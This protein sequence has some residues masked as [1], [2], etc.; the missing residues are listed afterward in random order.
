MD[1]L[2]ALEMAIGQIEKQHGKGAI[3]KLGEASAKFEVPVIP[4]GSLA[5]DMALGI[6]GVPRGRVSE[7]YG[8]E[9]SGKTTL[10]LQV[11]AEA[12]KLGGIAAF[13]DV[14]H[15]LDPN[16]AQS[17]GVKIADLYVAQPDTGEQGLEI[18]ETLVRSN[19][20]DVVVIDSVAAMVPKAEIEG[21]MG[22]SHVGLQARLMSQALRKLTG[23]ISKSRTAVIFINQVREKIGVMF[24]NPETTPGGRALKFYS[25]VRME[26]RKMD[27]IKSGQ[28]SIGNRV[29]VKVVKNKL[30]PPFKVAE[31]DILFGKGISRE[32]SL[33]DV[34]LEA[35]IVSKSGTW[36]SF[37]DTRLGQGRDNARSYLEENPEVANTI[38]R[39]VRE[40][41]GGTIR[42][43][44]EALVEAEA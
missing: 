2:K 23:V 30:A 42:T 43:N 10:A 26:V 19:A 34:G 9:S 28:E 12:Q 29:K 3:M 15:A 13:I 4:T 37:S 22:D 16:Y 44:G 31:F 36:F 17:L 21:E 1:K 40:L 11:I 7:I 8:P 24:G 27:Q 6:G 38:E 35:G 5:V 33:L 41:W 14:E 20:V 18:V 32:G 39:K 25:S